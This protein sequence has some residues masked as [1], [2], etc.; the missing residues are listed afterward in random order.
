[1]KQSPKEN[2]AYG[3]GTRVIHISLALAVV[4]QLAT[5]LFMSHDANG[6]RENLL[7]E[8]H[9]YAGLTSLVI[10][11]VFWLVVFFGKKG[12][13]LGL[14]FPWLSGPRRKALKASGARHFKAFKAKKVPSYEDE[15]AVASTIHGLGILIIS[16]M[17]LTGLLY[18][19]GGKM[20]ATDGVIAT[21]AIS[22]HAPFSKLVWAY[23]IG[24]AGI[25]VLHALRRE[26]PLSVMWSLKPSQKSDE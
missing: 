23:L 14:L 10:I 1:M 16:V 18:F 4:V 24:H 3:W 13:P 12:T 17:T 21:V 9:E 22:I 11:A 20:S 7:F 5:S 19:I 8:V 25:A 2:I 26:R 15:D 6:G